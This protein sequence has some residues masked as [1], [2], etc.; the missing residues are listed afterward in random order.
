MELTTVSVRGTI[1]QF[2]RVHKQWVWLERALEHKSLNQVLQE[3]SLTT[4]HKVDLFIDRD[5]K[6]FNYILDYVYNGIFPFVDS[7]EKM[8]RITQELDYFGLEYSKKIWLKYLDK[9]SIK[10]KRDSGSCSNDKKWIYTKTEAL[11]VN[12]KETYEVPSGYEIKIVKGDKWILFKD[13]TYTLCK[14]GTQTPIYTI[15]NNPYNVADFSENYILTIKTLIDIRTHQVK[16][17]T[18]TFGIVF[19]ALTENNTELDIIGRSDSRMYFY[20]GNLQI[21]KTIENK[22]YD[23][24]S[25]SDSHIVI[26][27][28]GCKT[29]DYKGNITD[30]HF[31]LEGSPITRINVFICGQMR[32][33]KI[34]KEYM[35]TMNTMISNFTVHILKE[36]LIWVRYG[37]VMVFQPP[38]YVEYKRK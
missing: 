24:Y 16:D 25:I 38:H 31:I 8:I 17:I 14:V 11:S 20:N 9:Y 27:Q 36:Y 29:Y 1:I 2:H 35:N 26:N 37:C 7:Y 32:N 4:T 22:K 10:H 12:G 21:V 33:I 30:N 13:Y 28:S 5:P 23:I 15:E 19:V 3:Q 6:L 18:H 34:P